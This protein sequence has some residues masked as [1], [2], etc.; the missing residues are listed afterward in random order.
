MSWTI[1][2]KPLE[3]R[4]GWVYWNQAH[5]HVGKGQP[6]FWWEATEDAFF[7]TQDV[8]LWKE[9]MIVTDSIEDAKRQL[10]ATFPGCIFAQ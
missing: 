4:H 9:G 5:R 2:V 3:N 7:T 6:S 1:Y 10:E 8:E